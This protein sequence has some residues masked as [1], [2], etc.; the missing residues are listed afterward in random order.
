LLELARAFAQAAQKP[1]RS[2]LFA[3]VT[4]EEQGLLGSEYL[5]KHPPFPAARI[6]LDLNYDDLPPLGSPEEVEVSGAE[7]TS[8]YRIVQAT[9][10]DFR[11]TIRP[12]AHPEAGHYYRSDHFS[13]AR[14]GI[15]SFS[16]NEGVKYKGHD[17]AWGLQQEEEYNEKHYHQ[18]SDEYHPEMD[19]TG[20]AA[21]ARF[22]FILGW[23]A[24]SLPK[25]VSW[26]KGDEFEAARLK[27]AE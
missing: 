24:A 8:F 20:D 10:K 17:E 27:S 2:I 6:A 3:A 23:Q 13:L 26:E 12:D 19:F 4:A 22:G 5:G 1:R 9:A 16:I 11:L 18:P 7:R 14:V 25:V 15:P 21:M